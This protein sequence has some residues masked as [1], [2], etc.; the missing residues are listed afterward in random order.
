MF[1]HQNIPPTLVGMG[2]T[3]LATVLHVIKPAMSPS[4]QSDGRMARWTDRDQQ[5][6]GQTD[7]MTEPNWK[8]RQTDK[9]TVPSRW[10]KPERHRQ[11]RTEPDR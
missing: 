11:T 8:D 9:R 1:G 5:M 6:S 3:A 2:S 4:P 7:K 10:K